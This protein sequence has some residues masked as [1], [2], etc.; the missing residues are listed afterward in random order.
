MAML[1][2][3]D[4]RPDVSDYQQQYSSTIT[5]VV[6]RGDGYGPIRALQ[7]YSSALP[8]VCRGAFLGTASDGSVVLFAG[9]ATR[10]YRMSNTDLTWSDV[11]VTDAT[12]VDLSG[13]AASA[14]IGDMSSAGG[15]AASFDTTT[16]QA[17]AA[18]SA[19][20]S[21]T[22]AYVGVTFAAETVVR[23][24]T[25]Y[26]SNDA[27]FVSG[28]N[29]SVT[30]T[31]Y[32]KTG[33][34]PSNST[35]GTSIGSVTFTDTAD[36]S[37]GRTVTM[38]VTGTLWDHVWA[39]IDQG[40]A[41]ATMN[42]AEVR[43][44]TADDYAL[45]STEA[46]EFAQFGD[47]VVAVNQNNAPQAYTIASSTAFAALAG[48]PPQAQHVTVISNHLV[49]SGILNNPHRV[50]WSAL[51]D[52]TGWTPGTNGSDTQD[53]GDGGEVQTVAGGE[54]GVVFQAEAIRR[55]VY[56]GGDTIFEFERIVEGEG[57]AANAHYSVIRAGPRVFFL[58]TSGFQSITAGQY[59]VSISKERFHRTF[60]EDW[61]DGSPQLFV[62]VNEAKSS[63]VWWFYKASS[64]AT[65]LFNRAICYDWALDRPTYVSGLSGEFPASLA[66]PGV[67][68]EGLESLGFTDIDAMSI[69][70]DDFAASGG[71]LLGLFDS[72]HQLGFLTGSRLEATLETPDF[73]FD[74]RYTVTA[75]RPVTDA[76]T[77]YGSFSIRPRIADT[78]TQ[79]A[80]TAM[81]DVGF[82]PHH[83]DTRMSRFRLR[84]PAG[85]TWTFATGT[86]PVAVTTGQ[87]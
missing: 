39:K 78:P 21:A 36:E 46:W 31:I 9:T 8:A 40:G 84:V 41:A 51:D 62:G 86:E 28:A 79:S 34:A 1:P 68:L 4:W 6:P 10:L 17:A 80:E 35:D 72:S 32:G 43:I 30:I 53:F 73:A 60:L 19:K 25:V 55:M 48:S 50:A 49:L 12:Q 83:G 58:G 63:R 61:D 54:F 27:G 15:N 77:V 23:A 82:C 57:L 7:A 5:N 66:Q 74:R 20:G 13:A 52:I 38:T 33:T 70:L 37:A 29:P 81:N 65:G 47:V 67:T 26:G 71:L 64:G 69:S 11:S 2:F 87:Q 59:P 44:F 16:A 85:E 18:C 22:S 45:A 3:G 75:Q 14:Y 56:V 24:V 76:A 42:C